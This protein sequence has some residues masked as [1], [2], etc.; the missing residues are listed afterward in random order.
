VC[1]RGG[2]VRGCGAGGRGGG[3]G[4]VSSCVAARQAVRVCIERGASRN[5][6]RPFWSMTRL[7]R[8]SAQCF[9]VSM[10]ELCM[11]PSSTFFLLGVGNQ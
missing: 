7:Q 9:D 6:T 2:V 8:M 5:A 1:G 11:S 4:G 3:G 10:S